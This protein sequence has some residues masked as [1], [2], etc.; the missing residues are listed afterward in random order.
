MWPFRRRRQRQDDYVGR[1]RPGSWA[2]VALPPAI[3]GTRVDT[4]LD[5]PD[6]TV[7]IA[8]TPAVVAAPPT[9]P[10]VSE[11]AELAAVAE[12]VGDVN[13]T[14]VRLG[15]ADGTSMELS[16]A[17]GETEALV[18]TARRLLSPTD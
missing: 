17:A 14:K 15:F 6:A 11:I 5:G 12:L 3:E 16:D 4:V 13:H 1:H 9:L 7:T 18:K 8:P 10:S 2:E